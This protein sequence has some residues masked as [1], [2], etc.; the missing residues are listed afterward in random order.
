MFLVGTII[1]AGRVLLFLL[2]MIQ[3]FVITSQTYASS[4][5]SS[6]SDEPTT[7][8][9]MTYQEN[10]QKVL[11]EFYSIVALTSGGTATEKAGQIAEFKKLLECVVKNKVGRFVLISIINKLKSRKFSKYILKVLV[12]NNSPQFKPQILGSFTTIVFT[13]APIPLY[14]IPSQMATQNDILTPPDVVLFHELLHWARYLIVDKFPELIRKEKAGTGSFDHPIFSY[15]PA[16]P[17]W[18]TADQFT[19]IVAVMAKVKRDLD[20]KNVFHQL[21][22][23]LTPTKILIREDSCYP[24][25]DIEEV[26]NIVGGE[27]C[28]TS[29][30]TIS[31][32]FLYDICENGYRLVEKL[33][34]RYG[35]KNFSCPVDPDL[36]KWCVMRA[37]KCLDVVSG[38]IGG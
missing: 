14:V 22:V 10:E 21:D 1:V 9:P 38:Y 24:A 27:C 4:D 36:I 29:G 20:I 8:Q 37:Q 28:P 17:R 16:R 3:S 23:W 35:H 15:H 18:Y 30:K 34:L 5:T 19:K 25:I 26:R 32:V 33:P 6:A 12:D 2:C 31:D 7:Y 11:E 13:T